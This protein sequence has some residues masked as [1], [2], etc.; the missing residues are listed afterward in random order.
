MLKSDLAKD[1]VNQNYVGSESFSFAREK[2]K[3]F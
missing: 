2:T 1:R 3:Q